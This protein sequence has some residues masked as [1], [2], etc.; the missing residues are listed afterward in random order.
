MWSL[1]LALIALVACLGLPTPAAAF[2][3]NYTVSQQCTPLNVTWK[4]MP[5]AFPYTVWILANHGFVQTYQINSD[6]QP[7]SDYITFQFVVPPPSGG[8]TS[9]VVTVGDSRGDGNT[10]QTLGIATPPGSSSNCPA[11]TGSA[12]FT[13]A[14]DPKNGSMIQCGAVDFYNIGTR[15]TRPFTISFV[16]MGGT[17][18]SLQVPDR[19]TLNISNFK[20]LSYVPF[21]QGTQFQ[22]VLG[23]ASGPGSG[24]A[25]EI[26]TVGPST[27]TP[28]CLAESYDLPDQLANPLPIASQVATFANLPGAISTSAPQRSSGS[29]GSNDTGAI[30]GGAIGGAI[31]AGIAIGCLIAFLLYRKRQRTKRDLARS[32]EVRF[33]DLD[34]DDDEDWAAADP[35]HGSRRDGQGQGQDGRSHGQSYSVS[36]FVYEP[37]QHQQSR[38]T[39]GRWGQS[40]EMTS[41][42]STNA[43]YGELLGVG[44]TSSA[45]VSPVDDYPPRAGNLSTHSRSSQNPFSS[46]NAGLDRDGRP[47]E[48]G[49]GTYATSSSAALHSATAAGRLPGKA[50]AAADQARRDARA[51]RRIVQHT[52]GGSLPQPS[53]DTEDEEVVDELPPEYG[54]WLQ[55]NSGA[56]QPVGNA[57]ISASAPAPHND[58]NMYVPR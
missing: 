52:D 44:G 1:Y 10:T 26:F 17:P 57:S 12:A 43:S 39:D 15:G 11:Y 19:Y 2:P 56:P 14:A 38:S 22:T 29:G 45:G 30:A 55:G 33:V 48:E 46:R 13:Y 41:P 25:S 7:N 6:Y 34:G 40:L 54:G 47:S 8:F 32:E 53:S 50:Q 27:F 24:G 20:Y 36:P 3:L 35:A 4:A 58:S 51:Q 49:T 31:A 42:H 18:V 5:S 37:R 9:Y 16:P 28:F 21:A 23:D